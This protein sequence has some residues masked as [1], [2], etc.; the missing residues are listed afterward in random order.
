MADTIPSP[1]H[2]PA[3]KGTDRKHDQTSDPQ[4]VEQQ[5]RLCQIIGLAHEFFSKFS[6]RKNGH[7]TCHSSNQHTITPLKRHAYH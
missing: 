3:K 6:S 1:M 4:K 2:L 7:N 5:N